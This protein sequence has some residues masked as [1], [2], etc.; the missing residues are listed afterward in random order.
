[1]RRI[2]V[3]G[4]NRCEAC[5][6]PLRWCVCA[7]RESVAIPLAV[8]VMMHRRERFRPSSTGHLIER[9]IE[10]ARVHTWEREGQWTAEKLRRPGRELWILHPHGE[11]VPAPPAPESVQVVLIDGVWMESAVIAREALRWGRVVSLPMTGQSR[12]WLRAQQD[13]GRFSTAEALQHVLRFL[14][15]EAAADTLNRQLEL[16]VYA[17]LRV[18]G[19][20]ALA[21]EFLR[22]SPVPA[23][24]PELLARLNERRPLEAHVRRSELRVDSGSTAASLPI[25]PTP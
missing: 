11:A 1:M 21:A 10:D 6:L 8:D 24:F 2:V 19:Y 15:L 13:G 16:H 9:V 23:A 25:S 4:V 20:P 3:G 12:Y 5:R 18:R 17:S 7:A 14:G 22:E